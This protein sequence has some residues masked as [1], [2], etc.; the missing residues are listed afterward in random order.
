[1][2]ALPG[3]HDVLVVGDGS[4]GVGGQEVAFF[5]HLLGTLLCCLP[6]AFLCHLALLFLKALF[7]VCCCLTVELAEPGKTQY[8]T[9]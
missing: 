4:A 1:M 5:C 7:G 9:K 3:G 8:T 2:G 6:H